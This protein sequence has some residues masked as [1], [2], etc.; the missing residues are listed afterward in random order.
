MK[1]S[2]NEKKILET[3]FEMGGGGVLDFSHRTM[4]EFFRE[5]F[6]IELY[7][8]KYDR[9][10]RSGSKANRLRGIWDEE[11]ETTVGNIVYSLIEHMEVEALTKSQ[12]IPQSKLLLVQKGREIAEKLVS[13]PSSVLFEAE[14]KTAIEKSRVISAFTSLQI[15]ELLLGEKIYL[16][17]IL[18]SYYEAIVR[19]YYGRGLF[20]LT[21]GIDDLNVSFKVLRRKLIE[22]I[23][24]EPSFEELK[25]SSAFSGIIDP[26]TSL[27][28]AHDFFDGVWEDGPERYLIDFREIIADKDLFDNN[29]QVHAFD[30]C[31]P[32]LLKFIEVEIS[33]VRAILEE[34]RKR[35]FPPLEPGK[36]RNFFDQFR[37]VTNEDNTNEK[38][39]KIEIVNPQLNVKVQENKI[40]SKV[41]RYPEKLKAGTQWKDI[42]IV[43]EDERNVVIHCKG[44]QISQS[45]EEMRFVKGASATPT[46]TW[47]FLETL[48]RHNGELFPDDADAK[49]SFKKQ[50]ELLTGALKAYFQKE[51]DPFFPYDTSPEKRHRSYKARF[52]VFYAEKNQVTD[53]F[54]DLGLA[55]S[56]EIGRQ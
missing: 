14:A 41:G 17:K 32:L 36:T 8:I 2:G 29:S 21:S 52:G 43:F 23:D 26:M 16:L 46:A 35:Q 28:S 37:S 31:V 22:V 51:E 13:G 12:E 27:Y 24:S 48:A 39:H 25:N 47:D 54:A 56:E 18:Y 49:S 40:A 1:L 34:E 50:K 7:D 10:N 4:E 53:K 44:K 55:M 3:L 38:I 5:N 19:A 15:D 20:F 30:G 9:E 45:C 42:T 11:D 6:E 33:E